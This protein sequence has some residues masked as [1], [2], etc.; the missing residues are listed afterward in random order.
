MNSELIYENYI[1]KLR[2]I[3]KK[4]SYQKIF[5][6]YF[7]LFIFT[8]INREFSFF[9]I[10][11]RYILVILSIGLIIKNLF[12][13]K[14]NCIN[15]LKK[16]NKYEVLLI[17][18]YFL[19]FSSNIMFI[20]NNKEFIFNEFLSLMILHINNFL[21]LLTFVLN[22]KMITIEKTLKYLKFSIIVLTI[23]FIFVLFNI[24][25]PSFFTTGARMVSI[26][27]EHINLFGTHFRIA[28]FA[29]DANYAFLF[30][31]T[32]FL[33]FINRK[34]SLEKALILFFCFFGMGF[35]FSKTQIIMIVPSLVVYLFIFKYKIKCIERKYILLFFILG[36]FLSPLLLLK[37]NFMGFLDTLSTRYNLWQNALDM[38]YRNCF[39][40]SGVG[41]FRFYNYYNYYNW[42]VQTH[43]TYLQVLTELGIVSFFLLLNIAYIAAK[44]YRGTSFL[45]L[46]NYLC[47]SITSETLYL[48]YFI[49]IIYILYVISTKN[50][51]KGED[52]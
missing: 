6:F 5:N 47:F 15:N 52:I 30:F 22:K 39:L 28:G 14:K 29:E 21:A 48:Q 4:I 49:F 33:M 43:S 20:F 31:Y 16:T 42:M 46:L 17:L 45:I 8:T 27:E 34:K 23:S 35:S 36:I 37:L 10:D 26:G 24:S 13:G 2:N 18:F 41:G 38:F 44:N 50:S 51:A 7:F 3:C 12:S 19:L 11:L 40:P 25:I 1:C 9:G 32:V